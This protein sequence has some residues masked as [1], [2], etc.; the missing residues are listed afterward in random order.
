[1]SIFGVAYFRRRS[2]IECKAV[3]RDSNCYAEPIL[4]DLGEIP[5]TS[6]S[7]GEARLNIYNRYNRCFDEQS[8]FRVRLECTAIEGIYALVE[9]G[10]FELTWSFVLEYEYRQFVGIARRLA[11]EV[12]YQRFLPETCTRSPTKAIKSCAPDTTV[13]SKCSPVCHNL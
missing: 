1:M 9:T 11:G 6:L 13:S 4:S 10:L 8:Q 5:M 12:C 3:R 7:A 2:S